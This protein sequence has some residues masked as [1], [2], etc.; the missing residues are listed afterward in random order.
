MLVVYIDDIQFCVLL[1]TTAKKYWTL[2]LEL[3]CTAT[4]AAIRHNEPRRKVGP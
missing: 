4:D 1:V 3:M 2:P